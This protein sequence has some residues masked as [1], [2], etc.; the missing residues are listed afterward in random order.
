[1]LTCRHCGV[2]RKIVKETQVMFTATAYG[3]DHRGSQ[4]SFCCHC[5]ILATLPGSVV[6]QWRH[7]ADSCC[8]SWHRR[9]S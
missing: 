7:L 6:D 1:M 3:V 9:T 4:D 2:D 8:N 5:F